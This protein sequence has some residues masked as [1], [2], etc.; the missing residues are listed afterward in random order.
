MRCLL[1][2]ARIPDCAG[3][4]PKQK[5]DM[6]EIEPGLVWLRLGGFFIFIFWFMKFGNVPISDKMMVCI[7]SLSSIYDVLFI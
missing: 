1:K 7:L 4:T 2:L 5:L 3:V 6:N